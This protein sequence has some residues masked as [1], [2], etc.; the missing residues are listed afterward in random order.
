MKVPG[1]THLSVESGPFRAEYIR[2]SIVVY[3]NGEPKLHLLD[4]EAFTLETILRQLREQREAQERG[5]T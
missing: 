2:D 4:G 1:P 5:G 3:E